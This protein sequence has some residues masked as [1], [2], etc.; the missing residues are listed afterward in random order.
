M[1]APNGDGSRGHDQNLAPFLL[2]F[3]NVIGEGI[4][5]CATN[6]AVLS[7]D[8]QGRADLHDNTAC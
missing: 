4:Q 1:S 2:E 5:P 6:P 3:G 7:L 8:Q